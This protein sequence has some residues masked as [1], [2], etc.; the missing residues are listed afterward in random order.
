MGE[1]GG[2][3]GG[4]RGGSGRAEERPGAG[5]RER[6]GLG[7]SP[8][9]LGDASAD[10]SGTGS[11][12]GRELVARW[13]GRGKTVTAGG[14]RVVRSGRE[15]RWE[16]VTSEGEWDGWD[17]DEREGGV[18]WSTE[19]RGERLKGRDV[20][21][22]GEGEGAT[23]WGDGSTVPWQKEGGTGGGMIG[24]GVEGVREGLKR[25]R[26]AAIEERGGR[27]R[28][29]RG[30]GGGV[31]TLSV[32]GSR[33]GGRKGVGKR[34][35]GGWSWEVEEWDYMRRVWVGCNVVRC[36][37]REILEGKEGGREGGRR[38]GEGG[39]DGEK[40]REEDEK[41]GEGRSREWKPWVRGEV[42]GIASVVLDVRGV[43]RLC[44]RNECYGVLGVG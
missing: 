22:C 44:L 17:R 15:D 41:V 36:C 25:V 27:G 24:V 10:E 18:V 32:G 2:R 9:G 4:E 19:G 43:G 20:C 30:G 42:L 26:E 33:G 28:G 5:E 38:S 6:G 31:W 3:G 14:E 13:C 29:K 12:W 37:E 7:D 1:E 34:R 23:T 35:V 21:E 40:E 16:G 39:R 8:S 11:W